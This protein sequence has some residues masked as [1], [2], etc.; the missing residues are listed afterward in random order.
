MTADVVRFQPKQKE[1]LR[2][3]IIVWE[4]MCGCQ[5]YFLHKGGEVECQN[6]SVISDMLICGE[7]KAS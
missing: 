4:C 5:V 1:T 2:D 3:N 7:V 6:C